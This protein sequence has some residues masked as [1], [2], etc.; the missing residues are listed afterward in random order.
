VIGRDPSAGEAT[1]LRLHK[2]T[3]GARIADLLRELIL[4][5]E[6]QP[7]AAVV[8]STLAAQFGVSRGPLREA[9]RQLVEEGLLIQVP[10]TGTHV[11]ELT[12]KTVREIYSLRTALEIFA[13]E[14]IWD[15]RDEAFRKQLVARQDAL[16]S[17]IDS[18][19]ELEC[20]RSELHLHS[21]VFEAT[22]HALL[23][24]VWRALRGRLQLYW[25][26]NHLA[27]GRH[28]PRRDGHDG[29]VAAALGDD[30]QKLR[31]EISSHMRRGGAV[32]E[33]FITE[34]ISS[35]LGETERP[36]QSMDAQR[37]ARTKT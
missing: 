6:L 7:G 15:H 22:N 8:E 34:R 19:K 12:A 36:G 32:T 30:L 14:L 24:N 29:Y 25:A 28:G 4:S 26:S 21:L 9:I 17:A 10:F 1:V 20:I 35:A 16:T 5:G 31:D 27:H 11:I 33:K 37:P 13:F 18:S 3:F 2:R 23:L